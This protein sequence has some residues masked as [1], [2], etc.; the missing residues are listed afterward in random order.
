MVGADPLGAVGRYN[1]PIPTPST[2]TSPQTLVM[3]GQTYVIPRNYIVS[4]TRNDD[5]TAAAISMR[6]ALPDFSG[7]TRETIRCGV[8]YGDPCSAEVVVI[9]LTSGPF[10][11]SGSEQLQNIKP[12]SH[13]DQ[14]EGPCGLQYYESRGSTDKGGVVHQFFFFTKLPDRPDISVLRCPRPGSSGA[15]RCNSYDDAGDGDSFY[16]NFHRSK[17]CEWSSIRSRIA[18]LITS[19]EKGSAQ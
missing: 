12:V 10:L 9:G 1:L 19:F 16:Y 5:G 14:R 15:S 3:N 18:R 11:T 6:A 4:L 8:G 7:L 13:P 17:L 2:D